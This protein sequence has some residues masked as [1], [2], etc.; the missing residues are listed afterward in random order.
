MKIASFVDNLII[1]YGF[2]E[3]LKIKIE[4]ED[5]QTKYFLKVDKKLFQ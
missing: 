1:L 2:Q 5:T 3:I 4:L